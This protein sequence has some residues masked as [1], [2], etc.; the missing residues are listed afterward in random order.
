V[1]VAL[2]P[3]AGRQPRD[4]VDLRLHSAA[5]CLPATSRQIVQ[6]LALGRLAQPWLADT[7]EPEHSGMTE[8]RQIPDRLVPLR[9]RA[10]QQT[11][12]VTVLLRNS[13]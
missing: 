9:L 4:R 3:Q 8:H 7:G 10:G 11:A 2:Q 5:C 6:C 13:A 1:I 12:A